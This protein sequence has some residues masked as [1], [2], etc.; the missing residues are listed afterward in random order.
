MFDHVEA[1]QF[2]SSVHAG[3]SSN[4]RDLQIGTPTGLYE[5]IV[6]GF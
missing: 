2:Y 1:R 6:I 5:Y 3:E 4:G